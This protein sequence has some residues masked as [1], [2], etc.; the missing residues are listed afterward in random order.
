MTVQ[1]AM[2]AYVE[3]KQAHNAHAE[4]YV[5]LREAAEESESARSLAYVDL[6]RAKD[7]LDEAIIAETPS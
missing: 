2:R 1:E 5:R 3:A 7:A 6:K 4:E